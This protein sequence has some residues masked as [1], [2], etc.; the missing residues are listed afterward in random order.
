MDVSLGDVWVAFITLKIS[1]PDDASVS[2]RAGIQPT[3]RDVQPFFRDG[4]LAAVGGSRR[5]GGGAFVRTDSAMAIHRY[6]QAPR[7]QPPDQLGRSDAHALGRIG[8]VNLV[9][10]NLRVLQGALLLR[11][12]LEGLRACL[13]GL[14]S[15]LEA[16]TAAQRQDFCIVKGVFP[17]HRPQH[18]RQTTCE[19]DYRDP[20]SAALYEHLPPLP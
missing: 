9:G 19:R 17:P 6:Q 4:W 13:E 15:L 18:S 16:A 1:V 3:I 8:S 11:G 14:S 10:G 2:K 7:A 5:T 20:T 12:S